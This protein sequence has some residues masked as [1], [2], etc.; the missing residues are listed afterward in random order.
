VAL[1]ASHSISEFGQPLVLA[2]SNSGR[3]SQPVQ[4]TEIVAC[5]PTSPEHAYHCYFETVWRN[6]RRLG[7]S[8]HLAEDATQDVF[9][10][11]HRRWAEFQRRSTLRTWILGICVH[12]AKQ[13]LRRTG[14]AARTHTEVDDSYPSPDCP[15]NNVEQRQAVHR[16]MYTLDRLSYE[17]RTVLVLVE[18]EELPV[19]EAAQAMN[20][21]VS[22]AY[23]RLRQAHHAFEQAWSRLEARDAWR[24]K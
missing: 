21:P 6:L 22:T 18:L 9:L 20:V 8:E 5:E 15:E 17:H 13:T 7:L 11:V 16:L 10:V 14:R 4:S 19:A 23:K 24:L 3:A 2:S 12:V 1:R